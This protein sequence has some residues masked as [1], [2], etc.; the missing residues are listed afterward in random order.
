MENKPKTV[1]ANLSF[2]KKTAQNAVNQIKSNPDFDKVSLDDIEELE[3]DV[4]QEVVSPSVQDAI[5]MTVVA[6]LWIEKANIKHVTERLR[7]GYVGMEIVEKDKIS[8]QSKRGEPYGT[9][10]SIPSNDGKAAIG[11][12]YIGKN[13]RFPVPIVGEYIALKRALDVQRKGNHGFDEKYIRNDSLAQIEHFYKRSL[14]YWNPEKYSHSRGTEPV[15]YENFDKIHENQLRILGKEKIKTFATRPGK[16]DIGSFEYKG[17]IKNME[18]IAKIMQSEPV[19]GGYYVCAC[20]TIE[21]VSGKD[22][23]TK[24]KNPI[25][26]EEN[27]WLVFRKEGYWDVIYSSETHVSQ[28]VNKHI[29]F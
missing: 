18:S 26:L 1:K 9:I 5:R 8:Y 22:F 17:I 14:A 15:V 6:T 28:A 29:V 4:S 25:I 23:P 7:T 27:D 20:D 16:S 11:I 13:E 3:L 12:S 24:T 19:P 21:I 2:V 10:V